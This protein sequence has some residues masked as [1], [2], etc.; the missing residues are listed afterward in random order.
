MDCSMPGFPVLHYLLELA[1]THV[2]RVSEAIQPY[3]RLLLLPLIFPS[4]RGFSDESVLHIRWPKYWSGLLFPSPGDL[5]NLG[6]K[7]ESPAWQADSLPLSHLGSWRKTCCSVA[8]SCLTLCDPMDCSTPGFSVIPHLPEF[9]QTHVHWV[10]DVI[11]PS[12]P[13]LS[14][15]P[16]ALNLSQHQGLFQ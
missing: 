8:K 12:H 10:S 3:H 6:I 7:H 14:P 2:H 15:S 4:I 11:Q 9:A 16:P 5:P 13:L 1:Q